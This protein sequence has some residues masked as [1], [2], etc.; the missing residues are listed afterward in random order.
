METLIVWEEITPKVAHAR[1]MLRR[2]DA[3]EELPTLEDNL[4]ELL[5]VFEDDPTFSLWKLTHQE[6][7]YRNF[8]YGM[9]LVFDEPVEDMADIGFIA[10]FIVSEESRETL[11]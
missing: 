8:N 4:E 1:L 6:L 9:S 3:S 5:E 2:E 11:N 10:S 7:G